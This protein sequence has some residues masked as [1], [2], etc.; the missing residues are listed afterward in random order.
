MFLK[1]FS[2]VMT[3]NFLVFAAVLDTPH[4][5]LKEYAK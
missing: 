4:E 5:M 1:E 2:D 3:R